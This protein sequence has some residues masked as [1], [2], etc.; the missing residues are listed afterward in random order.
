MTHYL[1]R[2]RT[3]KIVG[4]RMRSLAAGQ[5]GEPVAYS[6]ASPAY[7]KIDTDDVVWVLALLD[8][9]GGERIPTLAAR[10]SVAASF[11]SRE[12]ARAGAG[13]E[14]TKAK[15]EQLWDA[16]GHSWLPGGKR[17]PV[18]AEA[19]SGESF[20]APFVDM[21][22]WLRRLRLVPTRRRPRESARLDVPDGDR[23]LQRGAWTRFAHQLRACRRIK[24]PNEEAWRREGLV[25]CKVG[26]DAVFLS[27]KWSEG[28]AHA[29]VLA[30][31]LARRGRPVWLDS[32]VLPA[33]RSGIEPE[34]LKT[35][36]ETGLRRSARVTA[37]V[38][39]RYREDVAAARAQHGQGA[40]RWVTWERQAAEQLGLAVSELDIRD[41]QPG[42]AWLAGA[43]SQLGET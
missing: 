26:R 4:W 37:L 32:L 23:T 35:L 12:A 13:D 7:I 34:R 39:D 33:T 29:L 8:F 38:G 15:R 41:R 24:E 21:S 36:I 19:D 2:L 42:E 3:D 27:Y 9:P 6:S 43:L 5:P 10:I 18:V 28:R 11:E 30:R 22:E 20:L 25:P 40:L 31:E 17:P 14:E 16:Y 1:V